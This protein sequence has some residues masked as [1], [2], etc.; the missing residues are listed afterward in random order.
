MDIEKWTIKKVLQMGADMELESYNLYMKHA[1]NA[2]YPG[3]SRIL[4]QLAEDEMRHR[5]YFLRGLKEPENIDVKNL[6]E[7]ISGMKVTEKLV[8]VPLDPKADFPMI[9]KFAAQR[10]VATYNFYMQIAGKYEGTELGNLFN[11][12]A[13]EELKHKELLDIEY[14]EITGW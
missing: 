8:K 9:L 13:D 12:F 1:E 3:A 14:D 2:K 4:K 5:N 11:K 6:T 7:D 10:E